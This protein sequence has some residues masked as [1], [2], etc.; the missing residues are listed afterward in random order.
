[1][2]QNWKISA[3]CISAFKKCPTAFRLAY[4]E[5]LRAIEDTESQRV[6]TNWH[7]CLEVATMIPGNPCNCGT[8]ESLAQADC[9]ICNGVG[10]VPDGE[11]IERVGAW[12]NACYT[13]PPVGIEPSAWEAERAMLAYS[14]AGWLWAYSGEQPLETLAGEF[15]FDLPLRNPA[16]GRS[17]PNVTVV[18]KIDRLVRGPR[19]PMNVEY[20]STSKAIDSGSLYWSRMNRNTQVSLYALAARQAQH[21][22]VIP[23]LNP[24][25]AVFAGTIYDVWHKPSIRPKLLTQAETKQFMVDGLY[26][27]QT[28]EVC[29]DAG[30]GV[31]VDAVAAESKIGTTP[32][33]TK[34]TP[35]PETPF[36]IRETAEMFGARVLA[37]IVEEPTK[38]FARREIART[39]AELAEFEHTLY[40]IYQAMRVQ[41][42]HGFW[43]QDET[44][45]DATFRCPYLSICDNNLAV[46]DGTTTPSG[47]R[48]I[49]ADQAVGEQ[50]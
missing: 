36:A 39:D 28:F 14:V 18:G 43:W 1:M 37:D 19:G 35:N 26:C 5:G 44:Q 49:F 22:G 16:T 11:P 50:E 33:P 2:K 45:C 34:T 23:G 25:E 38:F 41:D 42:K 17:L 48:R 6:G 40:A 27:G 29:G 30:T 9:P 7:A 8:L 15:A 4:V 47:Y 46:Y 20:K 3:T 32:K 31:L 10:T 12:L 21:L 24:D 13:V